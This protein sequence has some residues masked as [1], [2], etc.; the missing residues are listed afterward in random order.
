MQLPAILASGPCWPLP[1]DS[2]P[3]IQ[4]LIYLYPAV[5]FFQLTMLW[6]FH[7]FS[8]NEH[9]PDQEDLISFL[10]CLAELLEQ[11]L[12]LLPKSPCDNH[13]ISI[14][15]IGVA[16]GWGEEGAAR[17]A[18]LALSMTHWWC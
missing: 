17:D 8:K 1:S 3:H 6:P 12:L 18:C 4:P 11:V 9:L 5:C 2:A 13:R 10:P 14:I 7:D 16:V 15:L